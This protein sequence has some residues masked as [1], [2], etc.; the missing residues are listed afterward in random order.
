MT[1]ITDDAE[2]FWDLA[3]ERIAAGRAVEGTMMGSRCV[4]RDGEFVAMAPRSK[5]GGMVV[6]LPPER[7]DELVES[8]TGTAFAP[9][10]RVFRAWLHLPEAD[11]TLWGELLD[12]A[13]DAAG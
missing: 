4:R 9:N 1:D 6:K 11:E 7:V 8:G 2:L 13:I 5:W 12:E 3:G 10:G